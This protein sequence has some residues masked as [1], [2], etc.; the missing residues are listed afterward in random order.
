MFKVSFLISPF[1]LDVLKNLI[2]DGCSYCKI[3]EIQGLEF[4][5]VTLYD[6]KPDYYRKIYDWCMYKAKHGE[7]L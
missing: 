3:D 1:N 2:K 5:K 6:I 4:V 7:L